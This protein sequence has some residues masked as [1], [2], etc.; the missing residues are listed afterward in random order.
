V[1]SFNSWKDTQVKAV[2]TAP[3]KVTY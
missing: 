3:R 2:T 1:S